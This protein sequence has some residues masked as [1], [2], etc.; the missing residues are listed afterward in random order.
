MVNH[1]S[2]V[3]SDFLI[4]FSHVGKLSASRKKHFPDSS[5]ELPG[6]DAI[7]QLAEIQ[8]DKAPTRKAVF[9]LDFMIVII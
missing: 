5:G 4:T 7:A 3:T 6:G 9:N 2:G 8:N 1:L